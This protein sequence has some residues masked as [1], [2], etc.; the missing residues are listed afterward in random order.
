MLGEIDVRSGSSNIFFVTMV[1]AG[2]AGSQLRTLMTRDDNLLLSPGFDAN[3]PVLE[4]F[5]R[6]RARGTPVTILLPS[7]VNGDPAVAKKRTYKHRALRYWRFGSLAP[8]HLT[9]RSS[10]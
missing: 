6:P 5:P 9:H 4:V 8:F 2:F 3:F 10:I 1:S 7:A